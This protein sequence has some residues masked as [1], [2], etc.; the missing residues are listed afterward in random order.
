MRFRFTEAPIDSG[1]ARRELLDRGAGGYVSFEGWVRDHNEGRE[2]T[3]PRIRGVPVAGVK[4]GELILA[5]AL[6]RFPTKHALC[7]HRVGSLDLTDMAVWVGVS[8]EHRGEAFAA[9]RF[10]IDEVKH[11]VPIWKKEHI[12]AAIRAGSTASAVR[13]LRGTIMIDTG[14]TVTSGAARLFTATS[15]KEV[16]PEGQA[17]LASQP[18]PDRRCRRTRQSGAATFGWRRSR[19]L[20]VIDADNLDASNSPSADLRARRRGSAEGGGLPETALA[21]L[22]PLRA[23]RNP[24][25]ASP[26]TR[27]RPGARA[28]TSWSTAATIS[29]PSSSQRC[30]GPRTAARRIRERLSVRGPAAG[31]QPAARPCVSALPVAGCDGG[32]RRRQLRRGRRLGPVPGTFGAMQALL[33]L[34][35]PPGP[36]GQ[37]EGEL[38]PAQFHELLAA[39]AQG[40]APRGVP[41]ARL[42]PGARAST[43]I[44]GPRNQV[45]PPWLFRL[46]TFK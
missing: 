25:C 13:R 2:V 27:A 24:P 16:G 34:R 46:S 10:I 44:A 9:C 36:P 23:R 6:R 3:R 31:V 30:R 35:V 15:L 29:A 43:R 7:I 21:T 42:Q 37:L 38:P 14:I 32:R 17:R 8:A 33:S 26:P 1:A 12:E 40:P 11:R 5:E 28:T 45:G 22:N 4:E 20:S 19:A 18:R 41:R 39:L